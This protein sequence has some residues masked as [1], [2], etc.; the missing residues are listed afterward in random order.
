ML[1]KGT[2]ADFSTAQHF[3]DGYMTLC[4]LYAMLRSYPVHSLLDI[5]GG[6]GELA[7]YLQQTDLDLTVST[8][9]SDPRQ[10][11]VS[12]QKKLADIAIGDA[13]NLTFANRSF[14]VVCA[15]GLL[16]HLPQPYRAVNEM[17]RVANRAVFISDANCYAHGN[18]LARTIK[19]LLHMSGLWRATDWV[20]TG[21]KRYRDTATDGRVYTYSLYDSYRY[22]R[23]HCTHI[24][25]LNLDGDGLHAYRSAH[26]LALFAVKNN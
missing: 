21:G 9:D 25:V 8:I 12:D 16:H 10:Q 2:A 11:T 4:F 6:S 19:Q 13:M 22:L 3:G 1:G 24:H 26:S 15:C 23:R 18:R 14:D 17:L 7:Q 20:L 5:G